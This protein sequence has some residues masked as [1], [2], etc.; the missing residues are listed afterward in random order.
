MPRVLLANP[1]SHAMAA[2]PED[3]PDDVVPYY[4]AMADRLLWTLGPG[5]VGVVPG[6]VNHRFLSYMCDLLGFAPEQLTML[7]LTGY[8]SSSWYPGAN[9]KLVAD[10][11][12]AVD[13][14]GRDRD[15]HVTCYIRDRHVVAWER[16][17][18]TADAASAAFADNVA[19][20]LNTKSIFRAVARAA[21]FPI[22]DG[23]V[24]AGGAEL[25]DTVT[26][27]LAT[28]GVVIVKQD[29]NSGGDG[30]V[31]IARP[32]RVGAVAPGARSVLT[33]DG[34]GR[35]D[36]ERALSGRHLADPT[37]APV[38]YGP[39][40]Y[41][42]EVFHPRCSSFYV[43]MEVPRD[44]PVRLS[45]YGESRMTP[46]W[47]GFEIPP[48]TLGSEH[49]ELLCTGARQLAELSRSFGYVGNLDCD[50]IVTEDGEMIFNEF[51]GRVGGATHIDA[52]CTRILGP[53]YLDERILLTSNAVPSPGFDDLVRGLDA[54]SLHL[55]R[56]RGAGVIIAQDNT[57]ATGTVEYVVVGRTREE[58]E[59]YEAGLRRVLG[60][61][62]RPD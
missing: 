26:E 41:V 52:L 25:V 12:D 5:D 9:P 56:G 45:N 11:A 31:V 58:A 55:D 50:A 15:W 36:V 28:T 8:E 21:G 37:A 60:G 35:E 3:I 6:P 57:V 14:L 39:A 27:L 40:A 34:P 61:S 38:G 4:D 49:T 43:E 42:V 51:N 18:G 20:M 16:A 32:G 7:S 10:V 2:R 54:A 46:L 48:R 29:M 33:V 47:S 17:L 1:F 44:G 30:N 23:R 62:D 19:E 22:A 13:R 53:G 24:V 59:E